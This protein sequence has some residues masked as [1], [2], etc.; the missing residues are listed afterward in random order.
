MNYKRY[1]QGFVSNYKL[2]VVIT[3]VKQSDSNT[4]KRA[5]SPRQ[6]RAVPFIV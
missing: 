4:P 1:V 2:F 5:P 3:Q 6:G